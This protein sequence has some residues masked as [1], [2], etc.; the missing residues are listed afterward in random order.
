M[1]RL[2]LSTP[3]HQSYRG[4]K[5]VRVAESGGPGR[6]IIIAVVALLVVVFIAF[7]VFQSMFSTGETPYQPT[8]AANASPTVL[9]ELSPNAPPAGRPTPQQP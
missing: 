5:K 3:R 8:P 2:L 1:A 6:T 4:C 7:C 9:V